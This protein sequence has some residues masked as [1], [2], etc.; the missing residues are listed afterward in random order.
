MKLTDEEFALFTE[1]FINILKNSQMRA[2]ECMF[3]ALYNIV[4][5]IANNIRGTELDCS[6]QNKKIKGFLTEICTEE[7]LLLINPKLLL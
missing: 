1:E 4:P 3:K 5:K 2:G 6:F 7:Q